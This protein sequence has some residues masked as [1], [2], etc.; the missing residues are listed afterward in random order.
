MEPSWKGRKRRGGNIQ[1]HAGDV[2]GGAY[3]LHAH[4]SSRELKAVTLTR[5]SVRKRPSR[6]PF[7]FLSPQFFPFSTKNARISTL[8]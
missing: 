4:V 7:F 3:V 8:H 5:G 6:D 1:R 2:P